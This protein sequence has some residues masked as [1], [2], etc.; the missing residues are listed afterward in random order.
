[1]TAARILERDGR[2]DD[3]AQLWQRVGDEY[4]TYE[5]A[6]TALL[7]AGIMQYRQTDYPA[8]LPL[9][10]RSLVLATNTEDQARGQLWVGK[11]RQKLGNQSD[12]QN[13]WQLAQ[14][15]DPG[16]Y[17]SEHAADLLNDRKPFSA[18]AAT[19]LDFDLPGERAAADSW[20]RLTFSLPRMQ[21]SWDSAAWRP[22]H[23]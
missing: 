6:S 11:T 10:D 22:T 17:Y 7:F 23:V 2:F 3:A 4:P 12:A 14:A 5:Q 8:A 20:M 21:T 1:M 16:G 9:F 15:A 13:A 19:D 18:A